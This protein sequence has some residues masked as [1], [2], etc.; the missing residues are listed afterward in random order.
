MVTCSTLCVNEIL[1]ERLA[2]MRNFDHSSASSAP[3]AI[4]T[5]A[6]TSTSSF[7][8]SQDDP[9][10]PSGEAPTTSSSSSCCSCPVTPYP[11]LRKFYRNFRLFDFWNE[12]GSSIRDVLVA[13]CAGQPASSDRLLIFTTGS[14]TFTPHQIGIKRITPALLKQRTPFR[15]NGWGDFQEKLTTTTTA[16]TTEA[17]A[18]LEE[19]PIDDPDG[20]RMQLDGMNS[21]DNV[22]AEEEDEVE[23]NDNNADDDE[24]DAGDGND[25]VAV[26]EEEDGAMGILAMFQD[27]EFPPPADRRREAL[28]A[29]DQIIEM[30]GHVIGMRLSPDHRY[31]YVN[32][33]A[34]TE[35]FRG[36]DGD[37]WEW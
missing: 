12:N 8:H 20:N 31:L 7:S 18:R 14:K 19:R 28:D 32:L 17:T 36:D 9:S 24:D 4:P 23:D 22:A 16:T 2:F 21:N 10:P 35:E 27:A 25:M 11:P 37:D 26:P 5:H 33:R 29:P 3:S 1:P 30:N 13:S 6:T 15:R 34:W